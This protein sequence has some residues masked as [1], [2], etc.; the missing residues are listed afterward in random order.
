MREIEKMPVVPLKH[1][2][3]WVAATLMVIVAAGLI[4]SMV[5]NPRF[6]WNTVAHYM[7]D[8]SILSGLLTTVWLTLAAM[9]IGI[10]L[11]TMIALMRMSQNPVLESIANGYLWAFRG[12]P[13]LVQLIFWFNLSALYPQIT[14]GFPIG[15][16][17]GTFDANTYITVYV[18]ALLG[19]GLNEGAY[20]S[21]IVRSGL[22]AVPAGQREAAEALGMSSMRV[23][24]RVILPQ[25]MK[26][27]IPPTGNQLIGMLKTTSLVSVIALEELLY[28]AQLIY[29]ANFQTIPLLIVASI[30]YLILTTV[31]TLFQHF[32][33]R[34]FGR[35]DRHSHLNSA[36]CD[37]DAASAKGA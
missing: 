17:L 29:T 37:D 20:M 34:H 35:S 25:A 2:G 21:E 18:A 1:R 23:M 15:P 28:S 33:E 11:G 4:M 12:T 8:P 26:I 14:L 7:F 9:I 27:I 36:P 31:L 5:T 30:W 32:L 13:L 6:Q 22:N 19:L 3:R 24:F 10:V 16:N